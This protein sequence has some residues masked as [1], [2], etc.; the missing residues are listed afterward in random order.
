MNIFYLHHNPTKAA[1][2]LCDVHVRKMLL[3]SVQ[4][5]SSTYMNH[6]VVPGRKVYKP[7]HLGHPCTQWVAESPAHYKWL[8]MHAVALGKENE[9]RFHK[10]HLSSFLLPDL[11]WVPTEDG[12]THPFS[13][14]PQCMPAAY[15]VG[16]D[17]VTAYRRYYCGEKLSFATW[18][19]RE[20]PEFVSSS[21]SS[22]STPS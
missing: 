4:I 10:Y 14:P 13:E 6:G 20:M 22:L 8:W 18:T 19:R 12:E 11:K 17:S 5:L 9:F 16:G 3:E 15:K 21:S 1:Q 2:M 7:T